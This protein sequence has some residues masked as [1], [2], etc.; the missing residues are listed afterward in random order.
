MTKPAITK[1]ATKGSALTYTEL[2]TNFQNLSDATWGVTDGTNSYDFNLN[3][4]LTFTAGTNVTLGVNPSTGAVTINSSGGGT[5]QSGLNGY[6]PVYLGDGTT[7]NDTVISYS[8]SNGVGINLTANSGPDFQIN[9]VV[10]VNSLVSGAISGSTITSTLTIGNSFFYKTQTASINTAM[11][12]ELILDNLKVRVNNVSGTLGQLQARA[13]SSNFNAYTTCL[14]NK[15]GS[16]LVNDTNSTSIN[17]T[18]SAWASI[19]ASTTIAAGGDVIEVHLTDHSNDRVY[20]ITTIHGNNTTGAY[21]SI[22]RM[23]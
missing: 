16:A 19:G 14:T 7:L 3:D 8:S 23:L 20:R 2:D 11:D 5:I 21:I 4:R 1:R 13:V 18:T 10:K 6:L 15:A 22:E 12:T 9:N 17:F